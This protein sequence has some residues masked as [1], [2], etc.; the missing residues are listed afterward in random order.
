MVKGEER[1]HVAGAASPVNGTP[2]VERQV[3]GCPENGRRCAVLR[4]GSFLEVPD[5]FHV[6]EPVYRDRRPNLV[7]PDFS[8][9]WYGRLGHGRGQSLMVGVGVEQPRGV[10]GIRPEVRHMVRDGRAEPTE[11][12]RQAPVFETEE[13]WRRR[14]QY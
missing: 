14:S 3:T 6:D 4:H 5:L 9:G 10:Y 1:L 13:N 2:P 11:G 8:L 12:A 7:A